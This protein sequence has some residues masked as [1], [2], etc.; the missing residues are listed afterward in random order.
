MLYNQTKGIAKHYK[1]TMV[2]Q[3][4]APNSYVD[5]AGQYGLFFFLNTMLTLQKYSLFN[6]LQLPTEYTTSQL[7]SKLKPQLFPSNVQ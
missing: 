2:R 1:C 4:L 7:L 6:V 3:Q 5:A